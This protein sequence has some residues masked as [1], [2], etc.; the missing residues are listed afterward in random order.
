MSD[1]LTAAIPAEPQVIPSFYL[2]GEPHRTVG[3]RFLHLEALDDRS[4][5]SD[6]NIRAHSHL[7]LNHLFFIEQ[8]GGEMQADAEVIGFQAPCLLLVPARLVHAF[9]YEAETR[10]SVL[11]IADPYLREILRRDADMGRLFAA[12][13]QVELDDATPIAARLRDLA[14]ELAWQAPGHDAAVEAILTSIFVAALRLHHAAQAGPAAPPGSQAGLVA[15]FRGLVEERY[16]SPLGVPDYAA[17]LAVTPKRLRGACLKVAGEDRSRTPAARSQAADALFEHDPD[18]DRL[19]FGLQRPG[20]LFPF[21]PLGGRH[22]AAP[23]SRLPAS[24]LIKAAAMTEIGP[25]C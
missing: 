13:A 17:L 7:H 20:L 9:T 25:V 6:W 24:S 11:T 10:G 5:P 2:Y 14:G 21:L 8:G 16:R 1:G 15:R 18:R 4:R 23:V 12:A 22:G 19:P 3:E